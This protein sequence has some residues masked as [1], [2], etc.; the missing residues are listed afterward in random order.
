MPRYGTHSELIG[1]FVLFFFASNRDK[2][3]MSITA[4]ISTDISYGLFL[5]NHSVLDITESEFVILPAIMCQRLKG[6]T[7][8]HL[9]GF[10]RVGI[11]RHEVESTQQ[12]IERI[13]AACGNILSDVGR[14]SD[15]PKEDKEQ[16]KSQANIV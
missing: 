5:A 11:K 10:L 16:P 15:V 4:W 3:D 6:P 8:W 14:I 9:R 1:T 13:A 2:A 12:S 7:Y